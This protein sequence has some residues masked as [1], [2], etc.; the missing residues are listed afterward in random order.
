MTEIIKKCRHKGNWVKGV[1]KYKNKRYKKHTVDLRKHRTPHIYIYYESFSSIHYKEFT[2]L[3]TFMF[4][5]FCHLSFKNSHIQVS[6]N[7]K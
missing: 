6:M 4:T 1:Y 7:V 3:C 2:Y 5:L